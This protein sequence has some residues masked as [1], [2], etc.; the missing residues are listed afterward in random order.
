[1][2]E[3]LLTVVNG[4]TENSWEASESSWVA[5]GFWHHL[6]GCR[7]AKPHVGT[8]LFPTL[9]NPLDINNRI[10]LGSSNHFQI[11]ITLCA[12]QPEG[13]TACAHITDDFPYQVGR[14]LKSEPW[15]IF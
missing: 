10:S 12:S 8:L 2:T 4:V 13:N 9:G 11:N 6:M 1:M 5:P 7:I 3:K 14:K 15:N